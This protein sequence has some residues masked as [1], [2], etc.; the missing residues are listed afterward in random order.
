MISVSLIQLSWAASH[1]RVVALAVHCC[2]LYLSVYM[3]E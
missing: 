3:N 2:V 1:I